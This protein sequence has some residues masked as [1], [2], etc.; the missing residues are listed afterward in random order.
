MIQKA[1]SFKTDDGQMFNTIEEAQK[2]SLELLL[3]PALKTVPETNREIADAI[4]SLREKVIDCLTM[5]PSSKPSARKINGGTRKR[6]PKV[7]PAVAPEKV[8]AA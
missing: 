1:T 4:L 3:A 6:T 2:H 7:V 8:G 5:K